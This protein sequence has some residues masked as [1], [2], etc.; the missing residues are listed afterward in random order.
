MSALGPDPAV[1]LTPNRTFNLAQTDVQRADSFRAMATD[2][3]RTAPAGLAH[4]L[5]HN[6]VRVEALQQPPEL[7]R[8]KDEFPRCSAQPIDGL[9]RQDKRRGLLIQIVEFRPVGAAKGRSIAQT[10]AFGTRG[11]FGDIRRRFQLPII[12]SRPRWRF[13][14][15]TSAA[16]VLRH[17]RVAYRVDLASLRWSIS[18]EAGQ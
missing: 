15:P 18:W 2:S 16:R 8:F 3:G 9:A 4:A 6:D 10:S 13:P 11:T 17:E 12:A 7:G 14:C 1:R 5:S